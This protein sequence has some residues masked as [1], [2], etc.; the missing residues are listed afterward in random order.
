MG[1]NKRLIGKTVLC[2][3]L[4]LMFTGCGKKDSNKK[5]S[6]NDNKTEITTDAGNSSTSDANNPGGTDGDDSASDATTDNTVDTTDGTS[7]TES[8]VQSD[9]PLIK[10]E[11]YFMDITSMI[12]EIEGMALADYGLQDSDTMILMYN[13]DYFGGYEEDK[14][15]LYTLKLSTG[16]CS[17]IYKDFNGSTYSDL[18]LLSASPVVLYNSPRKM[19]L[20]PESGVAASVTPVTR[21]GED[22]YFNSVYSTDYGIVFLDVDGNLYLGNPEGDTITPQ[23]IWEAA[24]E[25]TEYQVYHFYDGGITLK[26]RPL[27]TDE[28]ESAYININ[29]P[30]GSLNESYCYDGIELPEVFNNKICANAMVAENLKKEGAIYITLNNETLFKIKPEHESDSLADAVNGRNMVSFSSDSVKGGIIVFRLDI[31]SDDAVTGSEYYMYNLNMVE[32]D[33]KLINQ[34]KEFTPVAATMENSDKLAREIEEKYHVVLSYGDD[35]YLPEGYVIEKNSDA[36]ALLYTFDVLNHALALYPDNFFANIPG[37][38]NQLRFIFVG[39][40]SQEGYRYGYLS[41]LRMI[42]DEADCYDIY[43]SMKF[44]QSTPIERTTIYHEI[45][46]MMLDVAEEQ[47]NF[48]AETFNG[49]NPEGFYYVGNYSDE[50]EDPSK[51]TQYDLDEDGGYSNVYFVNEYSMTML[52]EDVAELMGHLLG[53]DREFY[54]SEH[55]QEKLTYYFEAVRKSFDTTNWPEKTSWEEKLDSYK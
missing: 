26:A 10:N 17:K 20:Y 4:A 40:I 13:N 39:Q 45:A 7:T 5:D 46:H 49:M 37:K 55:V 25:Y 24:P 23:I 8:N 19:V 34:K 12:P 29:L 47:G 50:I 54:R 36:R 53:E 15:A 33:T 6:G 30:D 42:N 35:A 1:Y 41:G 27:V 21:D 51:Y 44:D 3:S 9:N 16:E 52:T 14:C 32:A 43:F 18:E 28:T 22:V 31:R 48:D 11:Q 2:L 38:A